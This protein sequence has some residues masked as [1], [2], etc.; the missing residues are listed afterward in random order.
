MFLQYVDDVTDRASTTNIPTT[1]SPPSDILRH[2]DKLIMDI[3]AA[4]VSMA[5]KS[6]TASYAPTHEG[7]DSD[8]GGDD[9]L[10]DVER[11]IPFLDPRQ[12]RGRDLVYQL[13]IDTSHSELDALIRMWTKREKRLSTQFMIRPAN[14]QDIF[15]SLISSSKQ[16]TTSDS[17]TN[18]LTPPIAEN[19]SNNMAIEM[20]ELI[21]RCSIRVMQLTNLSSGSAPNS[22]SSRNPNSVALVNLDSTKTRDELLTKVPLSVMSH[23]KCGGKSMLVSIHN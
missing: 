13:P 10:Q 11:T 9:G 4:R 14:L 20:N 12:C 16:Q 8:D 1:S 19:D 7:D 21:S 15:L 17:S 18:A 2:I 22:S 6:T 5:A 3:F 23:N